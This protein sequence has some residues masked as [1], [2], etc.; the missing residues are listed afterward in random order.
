MYRV[1]LD[2]NVLVAALRS[3]TGASFRLLSLLGD[4][5]WK[6]VVSVALALEY[7]EIANRQATLL[8]LDEWVIESIIDM[9]C[10]EGVHQSI[11]FR[12]RPALKDCSD[13]FILELAVAGQADFI[14]THNV[15]DFVGAE[16]YGVRVVTPGE[17]L[18]T[19]GA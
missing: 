11:R 17:F 10:K 9:I 2:T 8:G 19:I 1:V 18:R 15:R 6:P 3:K 7:E 4:H 13:E 14:V 12:V 16:S 5:R